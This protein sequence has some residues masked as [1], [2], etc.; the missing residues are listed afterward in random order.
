GD[1]RVAAVDV[2]G[3]LNMKTGSGDIKMIAESVGELAVHSGTGSVEAAL[4]STDGRAEITTSNG[5]IK[6]AVSDE[7]SFNLDASTANGDADCR[8]DLAN[9]ER[10]KDGRSVRGS[11][12]GGGPDIRLRSGSGDV[13][14]RTR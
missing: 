1:L 3:L 4:D 8:L 6:L 9:V 2:G 14:V 7:L 13:V 5:D 11:R 12:L 10:H